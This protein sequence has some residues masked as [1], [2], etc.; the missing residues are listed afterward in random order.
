MGDTPIYFPDLNIAQFRYQL[1]PEDTI[2]IPASNR[3]HI[4]RGAFGHSLKRL[5]CTDERGT[6]MSCSMKD[7][8]PYHLVFSPTML[9]SA[10]RNR[11]TPRGFVIKPP[12]GEREV[13]TKDEPLT[14]SIV[15]V[16]NRVRAHPWVLVALQAMGHA[17]IG[18]RRGRF[19]IRDILAVRD[20]EEISIY[21]HHTRMVINTS[22]DITKK[23]IEEKVQRMSHDT[24]TL[25]FLT[26]TRIKF[27]PTGEKGHSQVVRIP[28]FHHLMR[29]L[30]DRI[31]ALSI[32][33]G[34]GPLKIDFKEFGNRAES[35]QTVEHNLKW[36]EIRRKSRTQSVWHD[37]SG[38]T[39]M[40]TYQG[41]LAPFLP[42][43]VWGEYLH[44][45]E[46]AV[47]GNGWYRIRARYT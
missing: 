35:V 15:L 46:D 21:D 40:I 2:S 14:L 47:F 22:L 5:V 9:T 19:T 29:R 25:E 17:G 11:D 45:G 3:G 12:L 8:C 30:R 4:I 27:N 6:C 37:Q 28:A 20:S 7:E 33:Y 42:F 44:V 16:G 10:R 43:L 26:P 41:D 18:P 24:I 1:Y 32:A 36:V 23:Q 38:F 34:P 13:F 31:N 39:G